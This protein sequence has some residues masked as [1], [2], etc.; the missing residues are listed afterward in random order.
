[1][2]LIVAG[3]GLDQRFAAMCNRSGL[4]ARTHPFDALG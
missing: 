2:A 4:C 1:L 3:R